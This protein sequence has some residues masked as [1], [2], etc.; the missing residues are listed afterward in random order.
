MPHKSGWFTKIVALI[1]FYV[2]VQVSAG[3]QSQSSASDWADALVKWDTT[4][5]IQGCILQADVL[6]GFS[7]DPTPPD[8]KDPRE[9]I[10][11]NVALD[12]KT[13]KPAYFSFLVDPRVQRDQGVFITFAK[14]VRVNG[15]WKSQLDPKG[16]IRIPIR[17]CFEDY[18]AARVPL[19]ITGDG[20]D[21]YKIDLLQSFLDSNHLLVLYV[22]GG[23]TYRTMV[24]LSSFQKK[25][26]RVMA[27]E[28]KTSGAG[29][30][31]SH[32]RP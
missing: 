3:A 19:G 29:L 4:C 28:M 5:S 23:K 10:G 20:K 22:R 17:E 14:T 18:C 24:I 7:G 16:P 11:L 30:P 12:R 15:K 13:S 8:A 6:R 31:I 32:R 25:Y 26:A 9:Y 2:T 27:T 1:L 21:S